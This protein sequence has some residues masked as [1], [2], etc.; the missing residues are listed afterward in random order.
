M[1]FFIIFYVCIPFSLFAQSVSSSFTV[2]DSLCLAE[3]IQVS[4]ETV[5]GDHYVW[6][7]CFD[8]L[9]NEVG[10]TE[11][12]TL[13]DALSPEGIEVVQDQ[14][15][16]YGFVASRD[17][18][19]I[20]RLD[21]GSSLDNTP[22]VVD[23]GNLGGLSSGPKDIR[24]VKEGG[25]WFG[26]L[27]NMSAAN[28]VRLEFGTD[29]SNTPTGTNLGNLSGWSTIRGMD[30]VQT[31]DS[32]IVIVSSSGNSKLSIV[33]F[34]NTITNT[35]GA[36]DVLDI[37]VGNPLIVTPMGVSLEREG[38][39]W[40][41]LLSSYGAN[42]VIMMD[43]GANIFSEPVFTE[44]GTA[45]LPTDCEL[46]R[47]GDRYYGIVQT[48]S[49]G[50]YRLDFGTSMGVPP[51]LELMSGVSGLSNVFNIAIVKTSPTWKI[52]TISYLSKKIKKI[53]FEDVCGSVSQHSST[54]FEPQGISY[55]SAGIYAIELTAYSSN[56]NYDTSEEVV[57]VKAVSSPTISFTTANACIANENIFTATS[58][59]D[60]SIS[61]WNWDFG[62]GSATASGQNANYQYADT[63]KYQVALDITT[64]DGCSNQA[65]DSVRISPA[66]VASFDMPASNLC[67]NTGLSF[68]NTSNLLTEGHSVFIWNYN[69]EELDTAENGSYT[70]GSDGLKEITLVA[71]LTGC[72]DTVMQ[73]V[74]LSPGPTANYSWTNNCFG[75]SVELINISETVNT[76]MSWNFGDSSPSSTLFAPR[77]LYDTAGRYAVSLLVTDTIIGCTTIK[78]DSIYVNDQPLTGF[79]Y[80]VPITESIPTQ[81]YGQDLTLSNDS[82]VSWSWD[83]GAYGIESIRNPVVAFTQ[84]DTI[85]V[86]L[87][88][89]S[90]QGCSELFTDSIVIQ[91]AE[92]PF[93]SFSPQ[94]S[95]CLGEDLQIS[96][97]T[98][99]GDHYVWDF[100]FDGLGNEVGVTELT[101]LS[102]ALS[103]E[104]IEVVQD[105]GNWYGFVASRDNSKIFRLD[106][107]S[108]LDNTPTVVDLGNLGGLSSG[109]KDIRFVKEGGNWFG[110]LANMSA[111]NLVRLE[112]GTDLSNTPT[113]TNLGNL[114]GWSTIRGMDLVQ[115][116]DSIIVIVSS[117]GNSKLS[118]VNFGNT[119][120]NT[121]GAGDVLD[122]GVGNPLIV[123]PMGVSLER[124]GERWYGLLSSYGANKV[125]MM[126][127]GANI[128]S[129]PVFTEVGTASLP[130]DCELQR[131]GDRYYGIVQTS[132]SGQYRLD[133]GTSMGVP[134][135]LE[136][137]SGVSGLSNVFN[138]AIVKTSPTW[139]IFTISYL[140]K[141]IKKIDFEDVC[142]SV[143]QHSSTAFEPQ[144]ISYD[145]AGI[146]AIELTAYSSNG[147][148]DTSEEVVVVKAVSSPTISFTTANACIA[149]ENTFTA[150]SSDDASIS[151]W[152]WD[153]GDGSAT[154]SGQNANYQY[155]DTG[156]YVVNLSI[157]ATNGCNNNAQFNL[158]LYAVPAPDFSIPSGL[159]C[160]NT[161]VGFTNTSAVYGAD[162]LISWSWDFNG[163]GS[164]NTEEGEYTFAD[165]GAKS[166]HLRADLTGC[167]VTRTKEIQVTSGPLTNFDF[168]GECEYEQFEFINNTSGDGIT[169]YQWDFGDGYFS[170]NTTPIHK[171]EVGGN[172]VLGLTASSSTG[173]DATLEKVLIVHRTPELNFTNELACSDN[174]VTFFD[175][176]SVPGANIVEQYWTLKNKS[177][178]FEK[179]ASGSSPSVALEGVGEYELTLIDVSNYGCVDTLVKNI[180]VHPSPIAE[181]TMDNTCYGEEA[182]FTQTSILPDGLELASVDW[183]ID[184]NLYSNEEVVSHEFQTPGDYEVELY[185]RAGNF[186]PDIISKTLSI[187]PLPEIDFEFSSYC[188]DQLVTIRST[189]YSPFDPVSSYD[190]LINNTQ[191]SSS[192]QFI[193]EF[194]SADEYT[195]SLGVTTEN[196]CYNIM[197]EEVTID[198]RPKAK[199]DV[200]PSYGATPLNVQFTDRSNGA[201]QV[202]YLFSLYNEEGS[203]ESNPNYIYHD[204]GKDIATQIVE[205]E[206]GC[207]D[208][209]T[210]AIEV[211]IPIY[212]ISVSD[213][214]VS[215]FDGK[216][217]LL[218]GLQNNGTIILNNPYVRVDLAKKISVNQ[219]I[220][221]TLMPG[222]YNE[223]EIDFDVIINSNEA[224]DYVC[225]SFA[226]SIN[227]HIDVNPYDNYQCLDM[228]NSFRVLD[229]FPNPAGAHVD[230]PVILPSAGA[231]DLQLVGE[232]GNVV[233]NKQY[234][235]L[236][237]GLN[238]IRMELSMYRK[239]FYLLTVNNGGVERTKKIVIW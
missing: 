153:F 12:T 228:D 125:I 34:G 201:E 161:D 169:G 203:A 145:S 51:P 126:D 237:A 7:F 206:F 110:I 108:S 188:E 62:D 89:L 122:I 46:Q 11:L 100:C 105:Q 82:I 158:Q 190:W 133:F 149:N 99:N 15:N 224:L 123:T 35:P 233:Y 200:Y 53:D 119:I 138:I 180:E 106:F 167:V 220:E 96:N 214:R 235:D 58:S 144:G 177:I 44:V 140:S 86:G 204:V 6:D 21:F 3:E 157:L 71:D 223:Y 215:V 160:S 80:D 63:G 128:F 38:E 165:Q 104:G 76:E 18:S 213:V 154:A 30:L 182:L 79:T 54:A 49:S 109:P 10:V 26:I 97:T 159:I 60:A 211:V 168:I 136:L 23:L 77:H 176:S 178:G 102:D 193:Y 212:D 57:V 41:G 92:K 1:K 170:S 70:F 207:S 56:G 141:K 197:S 216:L 226:D 130:T 68:V 222:E 175:Q 210:Q 234:P 83:F 219:K 131:D 39:R 221:T 156:S 225:F 208:T 199:F 189:T 205:N 103:P 66:P 121:P 75:D 143:S 171:Y 184:G 25:N 48:S 91:Q 162:T 166:I 36:G 229:P 22:T 239:G 139:K 33:N 73:Q 8:G 179:T 115:T 9:G 142:G 27:A 227:N 88:V 85:K 164:L 72:R 124:E 65:S 231:C 116:T 151:E 198:P 232:N 148:Y 134:P 4:N 98:I 16:W 74:N 59:D 64:V 155:A 187:N 2:Q 113:G 24:F 129:E 29:L 236:N 137:M 120:T 14:G 61:E 32:I 5:N 209:S 191:V 192:E 196:N 217:K 194:S 117:S 95:V 93:V 186:C 218:V 47:D 181:L 81:F 42:K 78:T 31:T 19:K 67:T 118:I 230:I 69:N 112:F 238:V 94:D 174:S 107:G 52:F 55:D 40:Y 127:F 135:P 172:Y 147:N 45:S 17:N 114:S 101:T 183:L 152:N 146:Y 111:A 202:S 84:P 132:S 87:T 43:F 173:C 50:Q 37:G 20:F 13:S 163:E 90:A 150:T 185:V 28:L 195:F